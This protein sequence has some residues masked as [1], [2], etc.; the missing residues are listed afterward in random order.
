MP[1]KLSS[2]PQGAPAPVTKWVWSR[3]VVRDVKNAAPKRGRQV[4]EE[5]S[6]PNSRSPHFFDLD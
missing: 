4:G 3:R 1:A 5:L 6:S 2:S